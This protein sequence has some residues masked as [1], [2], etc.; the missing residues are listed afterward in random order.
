MQLPQKCDGD[1]DLTLA[2]LE[3]FRWRLKQLEFRHLRQHDRVWIKT[4]IDGSQ[5]KLPWLVCGWEFDDHGELIELLSSPL[6]ERSKSYTIDIES[7]NVV[8]S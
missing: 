3:Y 1:E 2:L 7:A 4:I 8:S 6:S 5:L